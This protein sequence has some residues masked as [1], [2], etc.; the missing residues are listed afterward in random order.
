M[1]V[2]RFLP[3]EERLRGSCAGHQ[4]SVRTGQSWPV[5]EKERHFDLGSL[6]SCAAVEAVDP[7]AIGQLGVRHAGCWE[8]DLSDDS[9][10]WS[11]GVYDIFGLRRGVTIARNDVLPF[12]AEHS[13]VAMERL[14]S[15]AIR[16]GCGFT[17]DVEIRP[18]SGEARWMRLIGLP[19]CEAA[20]P[21]RLHGLKLIV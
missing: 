16:K 2:R 13:R 1:G 21:V 6:L 17:I 5:A 15:D 19:V 9:L 14:R 18:A 8:C 10:F 12:Y 3:T 4:S 7:V 11:G 20:R